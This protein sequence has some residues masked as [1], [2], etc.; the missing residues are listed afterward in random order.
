MSAGT[1]RATQNPSPGSD[2]S[3]PTLYRALAIPI[4]RNM[5]NIYQESSDL[6]TLIHRERRFAENVMHTPKKLFSEKSSKIHRISILTVFNNF[7]E[8]ECLGI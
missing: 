1:W 3:A 5:I 7:P 4:C 8:Q 2:L 6:N